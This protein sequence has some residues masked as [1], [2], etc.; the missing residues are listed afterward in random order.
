MWESGCWLR[1]A[2]QVGGSVFLWD[3]CQGTFDHRRADS[4]QLWAAGACL[5]LACG[6]IVLPG[7]FTRASLSTAILAAAARAIAWRSCPQA[8]TSF[9]NSMLADGGHYQADLLWAL[10]MCGGGV[11]GQVRSTQHQAVSG[12][13]LSPVSRRSRCSRGSFKKCWVQLVTSI[14]HG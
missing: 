1:D 11:M 14:G 9:W 7:S 5:V 3:G 10:C 2:C 4:G 13:Q 8:R 6:S 12:S